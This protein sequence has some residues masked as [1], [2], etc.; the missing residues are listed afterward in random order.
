MLTKTLPDSV[1]LTQTQDEESCLPEAPVLL[2]RDATGLV[3]LT[4]EGRDII[5]NVASLPEVIKWLR[6]QK[7]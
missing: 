7:A 2:A 3:C 5:L 4:Q 6:Q 1:L